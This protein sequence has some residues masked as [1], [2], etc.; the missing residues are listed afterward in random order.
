MLP[1]IHILVKPI[2]YA[3]AGEKPLNAGARVMLVFGVGAVMLS[4]YILLLIAIL[5]LLA[6]TAAE[7][8]VVL[9]LARFAAAGL[10]TPVLQKHLA[11]LALLVRSLRLQ[12][13][14]GYRIPLRQQDAPALY[15]MLGQLCHRLALSFPQETVLQLGDGAWVRL[16]GMRRSA[17][18]VTLGVG[19]DLLAGLTVAEMEAVLAH[20]MTHAKLINRGFKNWV[21]AGQARISNLAMA[22]WNEVNAARRAKQSSSIAHLLFVVNDQL[23]RLST[24]LVAAYSRQDEFEADRGAAELCG[25]GAMKSALSKLESLHR[26]T[27]R[28]PWNERVA[29]L[30]QTGG[31]SEWL[32]REIEQGAAVQTQDSGQTLFSKYSTH[33]LIRDRLAA[34]P[35]DDRAL[36]SDSPPGIQLLAH[37]DEVA[38]KLVTELHRLLAEQES[39]TARR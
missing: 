27:S 14:V 1:R 20:E 19:Y 25:P 12:K 21:G 5:S 24:S 39:R 31:Y 16:K 28:L 37:P 36:V 26:I 35:Q 7:L 18:K 4:F 17:G 15:E 29:H 8:M 3:V 13:G 22:L 9:A 23:V 10:L 34:L 2:G 30:Q 32:L 11:M 6:L 38:V 33:P